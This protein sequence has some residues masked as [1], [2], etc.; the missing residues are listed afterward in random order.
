MYKFL[1]NQWIN[2]ASMTEERLHSYVP[3]FITEE[4]YEQIVKTPRNI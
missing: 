4:Q 3:T 1:L 2:N